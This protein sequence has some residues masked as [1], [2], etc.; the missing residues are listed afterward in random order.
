[1]NRLSPESELQH[2]VFITAAWHSHI[3][4]LSGIEP[5]AAEGGQSLVLVAIDNSKPPVYTRRGRRSL[6]H[7]LIAIVVPTLTRLS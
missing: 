2:V 3:V 1:M 6:L 5:S 7:S 4:A